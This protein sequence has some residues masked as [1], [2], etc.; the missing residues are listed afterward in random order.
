[1]RAV[2]REQR[3]ELPRLGELLMGPQIPVSLPVLLATLATMIALLVLERRAYNRAQMWE[4][5]ARSLIARRDEE[6]A[7]SEMVTAAQAARVKDLLRLV[8][9]QERVG[10]ALVEAMEEPEDGC[11]D[12]LPEVLA[13]ARLIFGAVRQ[14]E[15]CYRCNGERFEINRHGEPHDCAACTGFGVLRSPLSMEQLGEIIDRLHDEI[16]EALEAGNSP[17]AER[18][19]GGRALS[20][21]AAPVEL[22]SVVVVS[23]RNA[24]ERVTCARPLGHGGGHN[25]QPTAE[26]VAA[27]LRS[28]RVEQTEGETIPTHEGSKS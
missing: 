3:A 7:A 8:D 21:D 25:I 17:R 24:L 2:V 22:C 6:V 26:T 28:R 9:A 19:T 5:V 20:Q 4:G 1:M 18:L 10:R 13:Q 14:G 27:D 12:P 16:G 11:A 23:G 15:R